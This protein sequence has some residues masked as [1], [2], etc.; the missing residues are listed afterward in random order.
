VGRNRTRVFY[1]GMTQDKGILLRDD[2]G[3]GYFT[4]GQ[5][6]TRVFYCGMTQD[7]GILLWDNTADRILYSKGM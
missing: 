2:T 6:R 4:V 7:K 5:N 1:C 3:Q